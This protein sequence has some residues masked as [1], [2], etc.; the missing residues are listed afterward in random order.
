M[1]FGIGQPVLRTE[2]PRFLTGR[3][4]YV[5]DIAVP[6]MAHMAV[7]YA[8]VAH[9]DI[10]SIS[11]I[12]AEGA[13]GVLAVLTGKDVAAE[14]LGGI[15]P[16]FMPEDM[17][18]PPGFRTE[19]PILAT[20]RVRHVGERVAI[21]VAETPE[22]AA[23][24]ADLIVVDY[25]SL[26]AVV[27]AADAI[28]DGAPLVHDGAANN[29]SFTLRFGDA[30]A[31]DAAFD[32]AGHVARIDLYNNR[33][34]TCSMEPRGAIGDYRAM[35]DAYVLTSSIQSPHNTRSTLAQ[36]IFHEPEAKFRVIALDVGGGFG[37]K[38]QVHPE[39]ALVL[40]ASKH[41]GRP[42]KWIS[43]RTEAF[44]G[45]NQARDQT[46]HGELAL[47]ADGKFLGLRVRAMHNCG[48]YIV[49]SACVPIAFSL[50]MA[51]SVYALPAIDVMSRMVFTNTP[52][53]VPYRGAGRPEAI[54]MIERLVDQAAREMGIDK[55]D[56]RRRNYLSPEDM[57]HHTATHFVYDSGEFV[58]AT[59]KC[60]DLAD[61]DGFEARR[62]A[63]EAAGLR[64]GLGISY[65]IDDCGIF[66]ERMDL[67][68]DASGSLTIEAGTFSHGQGHQTTYAQMISDWLGVPFE[69][70]RFEQG[71]TG[72]IG[73]GRGTYASRSM[74]IGG[75]ALRRAADDLVERGKKLAAHMLE[76]AADDMEFAD[77]TFTVAGTDKSIPLVA[78]AK[79]SYHP[80][81]V[82]I[83]FGVGLEG[84][85]A[86]DG[87]H[88]S[89]P[90]GCHICEVEIDPDTGQVRIDRYTVVD[91]I[92]VV[93]NPLLAEG[94]IHG[95]IVQGIGQAL[96]EDIHH[97]DSGQLLTG[98]YMDYA[99]PR[100]DDVSNIA[101]SWH[102]VPCTSNPIGVKGVGEGGTVGATPT[103]IN[104]ILDALAPLGVTDM[105]LPATPQRVWQAIQS[106]KPHTGGARHGTD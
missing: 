98:S 48:A 17:G 70:I 60:L 16:A 5:D 64:R 73:I 25:D 29:T 23:E 46:A 76:A 10:K 54:Y 57:P 87:H 22:A 71:D 2:D 95:G 105:G 40:W 12:E 61:R 50:R 106:A 3:G 82:P 63:S 26:P 9:A 91:D 69:S 37:L 6:H 28:V 27:R 96:L 49:G 85:G 32:G 39:D 31:T 79:F 38:G 93:L 42:V 8:T 72:R 65:Y 7:V 86:F 81:A 53:T 35:D 103:V 84:S 47:D 90:N 100:A 11:T 4:T 43:D 21:V 36:Q 34:T 18:G 19:S 45:D 67:R 13:P 15:P 94:Q 75:S 20:G 88:P 30:A 55:A 58:S 104:A 78:V 1:S 14:G 59:D 97:D 80:M 41:V 89:F 99:T 52:P 102:S 68:F 101:T 83:E 66:N 51:P 77:G 24:A 62:T 33:I 92:G 56:L 74:T 44:L